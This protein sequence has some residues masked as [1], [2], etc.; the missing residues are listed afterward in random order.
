METSVTLLVAF[1]PTKRTIS[2]LNLRPLPGASLRSPIVPLR[3][4]SDGFGRRPPGYARCEAG[5]AADYCTPIGGL[6]HGSSA[7]HAGGGVTGI[8]GWQAYRQVRRDGALRQRLAEGK[9]RADEK[10]G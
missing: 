8:P 1:V 7:T 3:D 6:Y 9:L 2:I 4:A 10:G 5:A